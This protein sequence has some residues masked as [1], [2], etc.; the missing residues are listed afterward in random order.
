MEYLLEKTSKGESK[1]ELGNNE[2]RTLL[3]V[4]ALTDN[5]QLVTYLLD[6]HH[7]SKSAVWTR[8]VSNS[9]L[10]QLFY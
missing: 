1:V 2:D 4:A 3:H 5:T 8:K 7:A 9:A 10:E 6:K